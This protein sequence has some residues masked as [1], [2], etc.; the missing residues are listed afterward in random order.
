[1]NAYIDEYMDAYMDGWML[2]WMDGQRIDGWWSAA[3]ERSR[4]GEW[5][6]GIDYT[7]M[8]TYI[9]WLVG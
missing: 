7:Y 3:I 9:E 1:M 6:V 8:H 4:K 2:G 5:L